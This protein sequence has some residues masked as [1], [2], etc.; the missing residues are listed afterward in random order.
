MCEHYKYM[1][2]IKPEFDVKFQKTGK[3]AQMIYLCEVEDVKK[4]LFKLHY[5][6]NRFNLI[7]KECGKCH[8]CRFKR[9]SIKACQAQCE[10]KTTGKGAFIT[11]TFGDKQIREY[12][13]KDKRY[14]SMSD[15]KKNKYANYLQWTLEKREFQLFIKRLRWHFYQEDL[16]KYS[17]SKGYFNNYLTK[18]GK[19][20]NKIIKSV[21][22]DYSDFKP[23]K[24]RYMHCGEYG[25]C[26]ERPHHHAIIFGVNFGFDYSK[27]RW[28]WKQQKNIVVHFNNLL[29]KLWQFG[30]I[31][32]DKVTYQS[33]NYV[34]RYITKK[35]I[36]KNKDY[37]EKDI[38][39]S[40]Y[41]GR[42]PE[43]CTQSNRKG[44][45]YDYYMQNYKKINSDLSLSFTNYKGEVKKCPLPRYFKELM[46]KFHI[47]DFLRMS[48]ISAEKQK[49]FE[50][51]TPDE[52]FSRMFKDRYKISNMRKTFF[53]DFESS[54]ISIDKLKYLQFELK[55]Q[56][57]SD[58]NNYKKMYLA[59]YYD[60]DFVNNSENLRLT[61]YKNYE[62]YKKY[63]YRNE[64]NKYV[65]D[66]FTFPDKSNLML[67]L[68]KKLNVIKLL[69]NPF[70]IDNINLF[71]ENIK[72]NN[73]VY[74]DIFER[75]KN[76]EPN[77]T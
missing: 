43:F 66:K 48:K 55:K 27:V 3:H 4:G 25:E 77:Y 53:G 46:R 71:L 31:T 63:L 16:L 36:N 19:L 29:S 11:L 50:K 62:K 17:Q 38:A 65:R 10:Y 45:G 33:C 23:R 7:V 2:Q 67:N 12:L 28:S 24:I 13:K 49:E 70:K 35:V 59:S 32:T 8:V 56:I 57:F 73:G 58:F 6:K 75:W 68:S 60:T 21:E 69:E 76:Y 5:D 40:I 54:N 51:Y 42:L 44:L 41:S 14:Q 72:N 26:K 20:R 61:C 9:A 1:L 15:Y 34:A 37:V 39:G 18:T 47:S 74:F 22:Y 52:L 30:D 64:I